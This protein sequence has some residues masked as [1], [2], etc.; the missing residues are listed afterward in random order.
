MPSSSDKSWFFWDCRSITING[1]PIITAES[2][3]T[4]PGNFCELF[5]Q[6]FILEELLIYVIIYPDKPIVFS[7]PAWRTHF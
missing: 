1:V 4:K 5:R 2:S 7:F 3:T 6:E